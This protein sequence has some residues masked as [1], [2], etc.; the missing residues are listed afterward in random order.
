MDDKKNKLLQELTEEHESDINPPETGTDDKGNDAGG[1]QSTDNTKD[2][3]DGDED[4]S[5]DGDDKSDDLGV[6]EDEEK[7]GEDEDE[8]AQPDDSEDTP[9]EPVGEKKNAESRIRQLI[10]E[11][12]A[13]EEKYAE[14]IAAERKQQDLAEDPVYKLEDFLG[15][16]DED[17]EVLSDGEANARFRAWESDHK[18]RGYQKAQV[19][20]EQAETLVKLQSET[21]EAFTK[22]PEFDQGSD[23]YDEDLADIANEAFS[24]GLIFQ[25]GHEGDNNYIIG[26][27]INP[28]QLLEKLHNKYAKEAATVTKVNNLGDDSGT[29]VS[30][31]QVSK[32]VNK[33]APGF[34]GE[35]DKELDKLIEQRKG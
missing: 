13:L 31:R 14:K 23:K 34:Q 29:V 32:R 19:M 1:D 18:L 27:R 9:A 7:S 22:F 24:A 8:P 15:T 12:K 17:G 2:A 10:E 6:D 16:V 21:K 4:N 25:A 35:V 33:Y 20:K 5:D 11:K 26:S 30:T 28:G 3:P